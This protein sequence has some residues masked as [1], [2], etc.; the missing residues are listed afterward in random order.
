MQDYWLAAFVL[1]RRRKSVF[2]NAGRRRYSVPRDYFRIISSPFGHVRLTRML[3]F[4]FSVR[5]AWVFLGILSGLA[6]EYSTSRH[7]L[8]LSENWLGSELKELNDDTT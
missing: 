2:F 5:M 6:M 7:K 4:S 3:L 8:V 1:G